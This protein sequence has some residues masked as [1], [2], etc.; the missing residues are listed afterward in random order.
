MGGTIAKQRQENQEFNI[1]LVYQGEFEAGLGYMRPGLGKKRG[2][3]RRRERQKERR[4][5][6]RK[7]KKN[8]D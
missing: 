1:I 6:G 8:G 4:K 7:R 3:E 5:E 2:K